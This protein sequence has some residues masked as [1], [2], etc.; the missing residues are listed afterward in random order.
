MQTVSLLVLICIV[1]DSILE[2]VS[3]S[4]ISEVELSVLIKV[5]VKA[6]SSFSLFFLINNFQC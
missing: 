1:N 4:Q 6:I 3:I 2:L 5:M